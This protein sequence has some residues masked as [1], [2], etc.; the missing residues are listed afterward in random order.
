MQHTVT[1]RVYALKY[2]PSDNYGTSLLFSIVHA[3]IYISQEPAKKEATIM[4]NINHPTIVKVHSFFPLYDP[5]S[6][7]RIIAFCIVM[8]FVEGQNLRDAMHNANESIPKS[9]VM[10]W[11]IKI[12]EVCISAFR[13]F[14]LFFI[15]LPHSFNCGILGVELLAREENI[16]SRHQA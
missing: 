6:S 4:M 1:G 2:I 9:L 14:F 16:S 8:D 11:F 13:F 10:E 15:F 7:E 3:L 5:K 12:L